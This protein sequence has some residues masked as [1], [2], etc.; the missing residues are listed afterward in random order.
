MQYKEQK[1]LL[2]QGKAKT[3]YKTENS[4]EYLMHFRDDM[5][6]F[7][8]EKRETLQKK[9]EINHRI[10]TF[11][12]QKLEDAGIKTHILRIISKDAALVRN[13]EMIPLE[14]VVRNYAAGSLSK[15]LGVEEGKKLTPPTYELFLKNDALHDPLL[16][17]SVALSLGFA[18]LA[19]LDKMKA[20]AFAVNDILLPLFDAAGI[21]L[22]DYKLEF[23]KHKG[24]LY[25]ADEFSPDGCRLWDKKT[26]EKLDKDRFRHNLADVLEGYENII[27]RLSI[28]EIETY[29]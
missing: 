29:F 21:L 27:K 10:N 14:S 17:T 6:A 20:I 3:I 2:Y 4:Q 23:G 7:D 13:L 1:Q 19:D 11:I 9:G 12:M 5:S 28:P 18:Q 25:L 26:G 8:G 22:V 15:R 24:E 16:N